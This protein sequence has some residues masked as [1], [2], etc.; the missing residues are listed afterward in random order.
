MPKHLWRSFATLRC[1]NNGMNKFLE[2]LASAHERPIVTDGWLEVV[3]VSENHREMPIEA[4]NI[5]KP[6]AVEHAHREFANAGAELL[7]S[8][9][10]HAS[11]LALERYGLRQKA[12]EINRK[13][14]WLAR[15]VAA[16]KN[17]LVAATVGPVGKY[18]S[19]LGPARPN[20][21]RISFEEQIRA[22]ADG[23]PDVL[24]LRSFIELRELEIAIE[25][26]KKIVP[27]LP[28]IAQKTFPEDGALLATDYA[29]TIAERLVALGVT[30]IGTNGTVG[31]QRML[32][33]TKALALKGVPL[34]AQPD[35]GIPTLVGG[36]PVYNATPEYVA[37]GATR[38]LETGV[39][40]I[41]AY[42]GAT[43]EH[44]RA[45]V[46]AVKGLKPTT[47][48]TQHIEVKQEQVNVLQDE[49]KFSTFKTNLGKKFLTT[50][51]LD[52]PRG[53]DMSSVL[54]GAKYLAAAGIDAV[55]ISDGARAR[56]RTSSITLSH[57]VQQ[58]CGIEAITHLA[59]RDRTMVGL[60]SELLGAELLGVRNILA[61]TGD[62]AQ[63]GDFPYATSVYDIDSIG[64]IRALN[65]MNCG[66]DLMGNPVTGDRE[67]A[68][69]F[70]IAC[71]CNPV[72]DDMELEVQRLA[73]KVSEGCEVI[74]TQPVFEM[75]VLEKFLDAIKPVRKNAKLMLGILPLRSVRHAEFLHYEV[76]GMHIPTWIHDRIAKKT[77]ID[78]QSAE[79]I[80]ICIEFLR[81]ARPLIDGAYLM[82]PFRRYQMAVEILGRL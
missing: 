45:I 44:I 68:T 27:E 64:L 65:S 15:S 56:L 11:P 57:I 80:E 16:E 20:D 35:I 1:K 39:S 78:A 61:V 69:H 7:A 41:G 42:G 9:T 77:S 8:N 76:P 25:A 73:Q 31:P 66:R 62:P 36:R 49:E 47:A 26:A 53:L 59:C 50:V 6:S 23:G 34:S 38:L 32:T 75:S 82:P 10:E 28:I 70:L 40:I 52:I 79:G 48:V 63:I 29:H 5:T 58:E 2:R 17:L 51:E 60:Q 24:L 54:D 55:N 37:L 67:R 30:V 43:P 46:H 81:N 33:I 74:F 12:Y 3:L 21:V 72:A 13:G 71:G 4:Y 14:V 18:L 22:L 19:P